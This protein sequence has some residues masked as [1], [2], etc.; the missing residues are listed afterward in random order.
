VGA[1]QTAV[2]QAFSDLPSRVLYWLAVL[3]EGIFI[4]NIVWS[5]THANEALPVPPVAGP[6]KSSV[7]RMGDE[8][9]KNLGWPKSPVELFGI[10]TGFFAIGGL[11]SLVSNFPSFRFPAPW[12]G[13]THSLPFGLLWLSCAAPFAIFTFLY[14][15]FI[16]FHGLVF[17]ESMNRIHFWVTIAAVFDLVR[18]FAAW[19]QTLVS[20]L[21][22]FYFG[23]EFR[24]LYVLF[25]LSALVFGI[26]A[27]RSYRQS[28]S[29]R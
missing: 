1:V 28:S 24:W 23:P 7:E 11:I 2:S 25:S 15:F 29:R 9:G 16:H 6:K 3:G 20:K 8:G 10:G 22:T 5:Y 12:S 13:E 27:F 26:S 14:W 18:V 19:E 17:E 21:A 4:G